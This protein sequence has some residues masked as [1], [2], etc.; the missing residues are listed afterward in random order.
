MQVDEEKVFNRVE[1]HDES[2]S[3][4]KERDGCGVDRLEQSAA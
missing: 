2:E 3:D 1:Q 4:P